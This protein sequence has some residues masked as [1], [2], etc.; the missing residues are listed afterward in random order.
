MDPVGRDSKILEVGSGSFVLYDTNLDEVEM[1]TLLFLPRKPYWTRR[2]ILQE[3][4]KAR[5]VEI[6]CGASRFS[7]DAII[8]HCARPEIRTGTFQGIVD[9]LRS[10]RAFR[11]REQQFVHGLPREALSWALV[12]TRVAKATVA[13][14]NVYAILA[15]TGDGYDIV[16]VP[17]YIESAAALFSSVA[18]TILCR[19]KQVAF[20]VLARRWRQHH[21]ILCS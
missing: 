13:R 17:K 14:D 1:R 4:A 7:F 19:Q 5:N 6:W 21:M 2:W 18:H 8:R 3:V 15:L 11:E 12:R 9:V 16:P 10:K 20:M